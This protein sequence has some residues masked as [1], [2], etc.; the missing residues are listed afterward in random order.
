MARASTADKNR[1]LLTIAA[2]IRR[3]AEQLKAVNARDVERARQWP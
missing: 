1:A 3:D 2:A